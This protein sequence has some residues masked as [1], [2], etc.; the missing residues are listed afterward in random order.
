M[1]MMDASI[2]AQLAQPKRSASASP[3]RHQRPTG[4]SF[5]LVLAQY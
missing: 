4:N 5:S 1:S 2:T 3:T